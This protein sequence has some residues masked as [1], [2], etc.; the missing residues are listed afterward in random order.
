MAK[1]KATLIIA[2]FR[3]FGKLSLPMAQRVGRSLGALAWLSR[4]RYRKVTDINLGIAFPEMTDEQRREL[5]RSSLRHTGQTM[6]EIPLLW[7]Q[8]PE[9]C[10]ELVKEVEGQELLERTIHEG[11]GVVLVAPHLGN[12]EI[13]GLYF[14]LRY[15]M[16]TLYSPPRIPEFEE[17]MIRVRTR[18]GSELARGDRRGLARLIGLLREGGIAAIL[19]DQSPSGGKGHAYAPFFGMEVKTMTLVSKLVQKSG[20]RPLMTFAQRLKNSEGFRIVIRECEPGLADPDPVAA[21]TALN[22]SVENCVRE[23]PEQYQWEYKRFRRRPPG[24][25]NPYQPEQICK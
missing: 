15:Q 7:E 10:L 3:L 19:P 12:W 18:L 4:G 13:L 8:P 11:K 16:A 9:R 25:P 21:T 24:Q 6:M 5:A 2:L 14:S 23:I 17:Y 20:A 1:A 22:Q